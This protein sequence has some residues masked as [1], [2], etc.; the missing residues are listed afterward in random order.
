MTAL[1]VIKCL[2]QVELQRLRHMCAHLNELP[3]TISTMVYTYGDYGDSV[4]QAHSKDL[5]EGGGG[6]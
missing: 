3:S 6:A 1:D 5:P 4:D 2:E